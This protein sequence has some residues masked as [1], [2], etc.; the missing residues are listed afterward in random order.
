MSEGINITE[1]LKSLQWVQMSEGYTFELSDG[2][3]LDV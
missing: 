1:T 3:S 2:D